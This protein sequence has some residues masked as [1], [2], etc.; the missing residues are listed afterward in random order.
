MVYIRVKEGAIRVGQRIRLMR[1]ATEY[2]VSDL[3]QVKSY[4]TPT[5]CQ[6]PSTGQV[7]FMMVLRSEDLSDV[8]IGDTVTDAFLPCRAL[9]L[10]GL[11]RTQADGVQR[12][13]STLTT[14]NSKSCARSAEESCAE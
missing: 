11:Q 13:V 12:L 1:E 5:P 4:R 9:A 10:F 8:H 7:G 6:I 2:V 14:T 3:G